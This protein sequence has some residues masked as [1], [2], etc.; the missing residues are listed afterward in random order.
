MRR[1]R[2]KFL[3][4]CSDDRFVSQGTR[5][6]CLRENDCFWHE[7]DILLV[8]EVCSERGAGIAYNAILIES[9]TR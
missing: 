6:L 1:I 4:D 7:A 8:L 2:M 9:H 3:F 5:V